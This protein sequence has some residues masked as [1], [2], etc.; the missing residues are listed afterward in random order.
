MKHFF[1]ITNAAKDTDYSYAAHLAEEIRSLGGEASFL[2]MDGFE[3]G[4]QEKLLQSIPDATEGLIVIG[5]D[6]TLIKAARDTQ[7]LSLPIIGV[8]LGKLGYLCEVDEA[9]A[10]DALSNLLSDA[11]HIEERMM[12]KAEVHRKGAVL[13]SDAALN[14]VVIHR[15]GALHVISFEVAVN[16]LSLSSYVADGIIIST[17]TGSTAYNLSAGGPIVEPQARMIVLTPINSHDLNRHSI[18]LDSEKELKITIRGGIFV[19]DASI[20]VSFDGIS[21]TRLCPEDEIRIRKSERS[22]RIIRIS[23]DSFLEILRKKMQHYN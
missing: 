23:N 1:I 3:A 19:S 11:F 10:R 9:H 13:V 5:G 7:S 4:Y 22:A 21:A 20:D 14:D 6:G 12:L 18:V 16:G 8:N 2:A 17:P 15:S